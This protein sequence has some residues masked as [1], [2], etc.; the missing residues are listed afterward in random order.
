MEIENEWKTKETL[1]YI[2][3]FVH[4]HSAMNDDGSLLNQTKLSTTKLS[5]KRKIGKACESIN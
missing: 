3:I 5:L 1:K 2:K 4:G